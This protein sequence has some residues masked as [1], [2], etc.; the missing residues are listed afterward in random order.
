M[1]CKYH[2]GKTKLCSECIEL[3]DYAELRI[4]KC[5][6]GLEKPACKDCPVHCYKPEMRE[7]IRN[8]MC[9][10]GLR[11]IYTHPI[12]AIKHLLREKKKILQNH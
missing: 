3:I 6:F 1:Y 12:L 7:R 8:I 9:W 10:S 4:D 5:K 2:H 11:M